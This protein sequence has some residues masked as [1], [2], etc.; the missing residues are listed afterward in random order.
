VLKA[1]ILVREDTDVSA[2]LDRVERAARKRR[3]DGAK[4]LALMRN[5]EG[6]LTDL[7]RQDAETS[8][9]GINMAVKKSIKT[10]DYDILVEL[11]PRKANH[12]KSGP[13]SRFFG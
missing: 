13:F 2:E 6:V 11:A 8:A 12:R 9:Y 10:E 7:K 3:L 5:L 1:H 4:L